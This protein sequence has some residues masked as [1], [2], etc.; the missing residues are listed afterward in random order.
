[1]KKNFLFLF[2]FCCAIVAKSQTTSLDGA[3]KFILDPFSIGE[4]VGQ[5]LSKVDLNKWEKVTVPHCF[6]DDE[7][8]KFYTGNA[9]YTRKFKVNELKTDRKHFIRFEAVF[10]K[11]TVYINGNLVGTHEGGYTPFEFEI[12]KLITA[13]AENVITLKVDNSWD[14][15]TI[16]GAKPL[17]KAGEQLTQSLFY[18]WINYGGIIRSVALIE[19]SETYIKN[20]K[21]EAEPDLAK[22]F[23]TLKVTSFIVNAPESSKTFP[24]VNISFKGLPLKLKWKVV[25]NQLLTNGLKLITATT[26]IP[27]KQVNLWSLNYPNLYKAQVAFDVDTFSANF[28]IRK[29]EIKGTKFLL[30]GEPLFFGGANRVAEY[31]G[32]GSKDP[33]SILE[34]D[35]QL[36]KEGNMILSRIAHYPISSDILNWADKNGMLIISEAGNWQMTESQMASSLM[37]EKYKQQAREM[38]ERDWNHPS[39]IAYSVGNE[40]NSLSPEGIAWTKDMIDFTRS[41]DNTRKLTFCTN[42]V[43]RAKAPEEEGSLHVD[44]VSVNCYG[45]HE[46][47]ITKIH[48]LYP[49]KPIFI[50]EF[51]YRTDEVKNEDDRAEKLK[52]NIEVIRKYDYVMGASIWTFNHYRSRYN[53]TAADGYRPWGVVTADRTKLKSYDALRTEFAPAVIE[54][55]QLPNNQLKVKLTA[56]K[57]FPRMILEGH[58]LRIG[59]NEYPVNKL[60]PGESQEFTITPNATS[61]KIKLVS[62]TGFVVLETEIQV[63]K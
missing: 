34:K 5:H 13:N 18:P 27:A 28:G 40:Y 11:A 58:K 4:K 21:I 8:Y 2:M 15:F 9:W 33:L 41:I 29:L 19:R 46:R 61:D 39:V 48:E 25:E 38:I 30:N 53:G 49:N 54:T 43:A 7:K 20:I 57:D 32:E 16:P 3:W 36:M 6:S 63:N 52:N 56:R 26:T 37:R 10:Y 59:E 17:P 14:E 35:M 24:I 42:R 12:S 23:A 60:N 1:M 47:V 45:G 50:S 31:P 55:V 44:F 51:G 22:G 62:S